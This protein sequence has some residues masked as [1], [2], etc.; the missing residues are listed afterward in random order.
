ME[1]GTYL[2][3]PRILIYICLSKRKIRMIYFIHYLEKAADRTLFGKPILGWQ[4]NINIL[5]KSMGQSALAQAI[6]RHTCTSRYDKF[7]YQPNYY[8]LDWGFLCFTSVPPDKC[9]DNTPNFNKTCTF[10]RISISL[11]NRNQSFITTRSDLT[12]LLINTLQRNK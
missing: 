8:I 9:L 6:V 7:K 12:D 5:S 4:N 2:N 3:L 1:F 11:N 10:L